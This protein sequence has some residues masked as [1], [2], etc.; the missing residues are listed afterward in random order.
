MSMEAVT[1]C[2][3][4]RVSN[5]LLEFRT[6]QRNRPLRGLPEKLL[7]T[8]G[9]YLGEGADFQAPARPKHVSCGFWGSLSGRSVAHHE[10]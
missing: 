2:E 4:V 9:Q 5:E 10:M 8:K 1:S 3:V 6:E 7:K